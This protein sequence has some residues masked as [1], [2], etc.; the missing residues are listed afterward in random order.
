[1][2]MEVSVEYAVPGLCTLMPGGMGTAQG[3]HPN[4]YSATCADADDVTEKQALV[5]NA[6]KVVED[7]SLLLADGRFSEHTKGLLEAAY[8]SSVNASTPSTTAEQ[9]GIKAL[10][11]L[12]EIAMSVPEFHVTNL[13]IDAGPRPARV[14]QQSFGRDFKA[15]VVVNL[16]GGADSFNFF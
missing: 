8:T 15:I 6:P 10:H 12:Q 14:Q 1:M 16:H 2:A 9:A 5:D 11:V 13:N 7:L 3:D 4:Q